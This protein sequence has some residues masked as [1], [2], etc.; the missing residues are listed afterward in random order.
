MSLGDERVGK[1]ILS[2][3]MGRTEQDFK[4]KTVLL[5]FNIFILSLIQL[6]MYVYQRRTV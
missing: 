2:S 4:L 1:A 6:N 3:H 5:V